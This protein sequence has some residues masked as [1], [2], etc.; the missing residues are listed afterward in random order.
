[1]FRTL[2]VEGTKA[3]TKHI[4]KIF[5]QSLCLAT[6]L[7]PYLGYKVTTEIVKNALKNGKT[8]KQEVLDQK[9][10]TEKELNQILSPEKLTAPNIRINLT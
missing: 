7:S 5:D 8:L 10:M 2:C 9:L 4:K 6:G 1:M 3:D